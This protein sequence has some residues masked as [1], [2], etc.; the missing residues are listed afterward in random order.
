MTLDGSL[1]HTTDGGYVIA[2]DRVMD[3]SPEQIWSMLT[4]P[5]RLASWLGDVEVDLRVGGAF[6]IRFRAM[7]VVMTGKI[8]ALTPGRV[9]EYTWLENYGMPES[10]VRWEIV[11]VASGCRLQLSHR[12]P[13]GCTPKDMSGF[14][15]G[16]HAFLNAIPVAAE[17][18]FVPYADE[19]ALQAAYSERYAALGV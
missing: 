10:V 6:I 12:F 19:K 9:L 14:L 17:G 8:T 4:E 7:T 5:Q 1:E 16:W 11:P 15:G 3:R 2:F 18:V 13:P